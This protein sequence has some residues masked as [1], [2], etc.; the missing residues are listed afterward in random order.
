MKLCELRALVGC[1]CYHAGEHG[2]IVAVATDYR[3]PMLVVMF[4][5][6]RATLKPSELG[7]K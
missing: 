7:A 5:A 1:A 4:G 6:R 2:T 3:E